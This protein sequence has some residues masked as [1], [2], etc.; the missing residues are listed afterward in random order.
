MSDRKDNSSEQMLAA[1]AAV[2]LVAFLVP[3]AI[4][5]LAWKA[6]EIVA[7]YQRRL[8]QVGLGLIGLCLVGFFLCIGEAAP[9]H[10]AALSN[11]LALG[12]TYEQLVGFLILAWGAGSGLIIALAPFVFRM[13]KSD[14]DNLVR[15]KDFKTI[16]E[17]KRFAR[18]AEKARQI[19]LNPECV[20]IGLNLKTLEVIMLNQKRRTHHMLALGGTGMGKSNLMLL[21]ILH[22][23]YHEH[24]CIIIDPKGDEE[25]ISELMKLAESISPLSRR[26][27][28]IFRLSKVEQ[29]CRYN[30]LRHGTVSQLKD[31]LLEAL[32]WSEQYYQSISSEFLS[33]F[34]SAINHLGMELN[35]AQVRRSA[36][37]HAEMMRIINQLKNM[38]L[39]GDQK[40]N[41]LA[42]R[43]GLFIDK[44]KREDLLGLAAQLSIL[45]TPE[46][47]SL[48]SYAEASD[49][50]DLREVYTK[51]QVVYF[52]LDTL[53][54]A[55]TSRRLGRMI[56]EDVKSLVRYIYSEISEPNRKFTPL[57]IDEFGSFATKEFIETLK[58]ARGAKVSAHLFCQGIE[59]LE[60]VSREFARQA[61]S[62]PGTIVA[63]RLNDKRTVDEVCA[64]AGT[65][66]TFEQSFQIEQGLMGESP[67][68]LGNM[69][70]T[71]QMIVEH[72]VL[73]NLNTGEG[74]VIERSPSCASPVRIFRACDILL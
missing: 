44:I 26:R 19:F 71:K 28:K 7:E 48:F 12:F 47:G 55:D 60:V 51:N 3:T 40:A 22:A 54:N 4:G 29:S 9:I 2:T 10:I 68:G 70:K 46:L 43:L 73:K 30:P 61:T 23:L 65:A 14:G 74:V 17:S 49:E 5:V 45:D 67:T 56:V 64:A 42:Q 13:K 59:D 53:G 57:L 72:D 16:L 35:L 66:D 31:K 58:Q 32:N 37:S 69:R 24:P 33:E 62:N 18:I 6:P 63:L 39:K 1:A 52:Q 41:E 27:M 15:M 36:A 50:I 34:V 21:L 38:A 11:E 8:V 25:F 20:P